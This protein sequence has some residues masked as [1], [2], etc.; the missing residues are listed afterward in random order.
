MLPSFDH[1]CNILDACTQDHEC[2][3]VKTSGNSNDLKDQLFWY[4]A[5]AHNKFHVGHP[6]LWNYHKINYNE[7]Y[8][9]IQNEDQ[10]KI[11]KLKKKFAK[12]RKL[13]VIVSRQGDI[14][15]YKHDSE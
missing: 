12:T 15:G 8:E 7:N 6:N 2:L 3:V 1:F 10:A 14:V 11:D 9:D 4:K 5:E 13:K